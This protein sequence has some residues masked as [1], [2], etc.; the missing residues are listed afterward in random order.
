M[1]IAG[2]LRADVPGMLSASAS[3]QCREDRELAVLRLEMA[4]RL[5]RGWVWETDVEG[6]FTYMS[7]SVLESSGRSPEW[8]YGK[9]RREIGN[10]L[11]SAEQ[12]DII[13]Q[14]LAEQ[15]PFG[16]IEYRRIQN[17]KLFWMRTRGIP[18]F[19]DDGSFTGYR[20]VAIDISSE[21]E[22]RVARDE[23]TA[24]AVKHLE[25]LSATV[26]SFPGAISVYGAELTLAIANAQ[27]YELL[28][29]PPAKFPIG[30]RYEDLLHFLV[31]RGELAGGEPDEMIAQHLD[32]ARSGEATSFCR[33]RPN[34]NRIEIV[35]VPLPGGGFVRTYADITSSLEL[36]WRLEAAQRELQHQTQIYN[37]AQREIEHLRLML[38]TEARA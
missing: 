14:Q 2:T 32:L 37:E 22:D 12:Q 16:P 1:A 26:N 19:D 24:K 13:Q 27:Y 25:I 36:V 20:G 31:E 18:V 5:L 28:D 34:G 29:L 7:D 3:A 38:R 4:V 9:T 10:Y 21:M 30:A 8:H 11:V 17:G 23:A 35:H 15:E 6:R 33:T